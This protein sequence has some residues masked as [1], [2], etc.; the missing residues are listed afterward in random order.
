M[1]NFEFTPQKGKEGF[2]SEILYFN[3]FNVR[4]NLNDQIDWG[5]FQIELQKKVSS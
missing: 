1:E 4:P 5:E 2:R 3:A